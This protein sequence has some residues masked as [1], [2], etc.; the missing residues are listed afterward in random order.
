[1]SEQM[2]SD[3]L[4]ALA[5]ELDADQKLHFR[6]AIEVL[7]RC[8]GKGAT[9]QAVIVYKPTDTMTSSVISVNCNDMDATGLLLSA[10]SYFEF[11]TTRN[12]PPKEKF[13]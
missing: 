7:A 4:I 8:Y 9:M 2:T 11:I 5:K 3:D 6:D 13:N 1:M 12:A 10:A